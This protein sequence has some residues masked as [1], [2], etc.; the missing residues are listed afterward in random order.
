MINIS[1]AAL[2]NET[3]YIQEGR[4]Q[5]WH[6]HTQGVPDCMAPIELP[7]ASSRSDSSI[8]APCGW[9]QSRVVSWALHVFLWTQTETLWTQTETLP[10]NLTGRG[11]N[12]FPSWDSK[13]KILWKK[14]RGINSSPVSLSLVFAGECWWRRACAGPLYILWE[15]G[16]TNCFLL[17]LPQS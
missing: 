10:Q 7:P 13:G 4:D 5:I 3:I 17:S 8:W 6:R 2:Q 11:L 14:L 12:S 16:I 15:A 1:L 9:S